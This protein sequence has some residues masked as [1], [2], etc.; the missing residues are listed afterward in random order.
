[1][2]CFQ[3]SHF[4]HCIKPNSEN[5]SSKFVDDFVSTQLNTIGAVPIANLIRNG[6]AAKFTHHELLEKIL[7]HITNKAK[8]DSRSLCN[9]VLRMLGCGKRT[10]K[11]GPKYVFF[12]CKSDTVISV[13]LDLEA[14]RAK[15]IA[16]KASEIFYIRQRHA[17]WIKFKLIGSCK[18]YQ[19]AK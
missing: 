2:F 7:P 10:F 15:E 4:I 11:C 9:D 19:L 12:R 17:M 13:L 14:H 18:L 5:V 3:G 8:N 1:M 16:E 6:Y